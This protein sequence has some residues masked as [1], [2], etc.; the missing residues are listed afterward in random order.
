MA[1]FIFSF[2]LLFLNLISRN[3]LDQFNFNIFEILSFAL[4][5][6]E[7]ISI[8]LVLV[9]FCVVFKDKNFTII[10]ISSIISFFIVLSVASNQEWKP[11]AFY[12]I[13]G[14]R[15]IYILLAFKLTIELLESD[16]VILKRINFVNLKYLVIFL[17]II[18]CVINPIKILQHENV[19]LLRKNFFSKKESINLNNS[20][21]AILNKSKIFFTRDI[22]LV[23]KKTRLFYFKK[24]CS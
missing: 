22:R 21:V 16:K 10:A 24:R 6:K 13:F 7:L 1:I 19:F 2:F 15:F 3:L 5:Q 11:H 23:R 8:L 14:L 12:L 20:L 9:L 4:K 18:F 17:L